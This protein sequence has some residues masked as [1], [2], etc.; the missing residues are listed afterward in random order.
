MEIKVEFVQDIDCCAECRFADF[1]NL[2][3]VVCRVMGR[4]IEC[5]PNCEIDMGCPGR[6]GN[7]ENPV[8]LNLGVE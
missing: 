8:A 6:Q 2:G 1:M 5:D 3:Q 4:N 7:T